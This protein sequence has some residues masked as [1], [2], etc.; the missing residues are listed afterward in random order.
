MTERMLNMLDVKGQ[1]MIVQILRMSRCA[2]SI[3]DAIY[4]YFG[5]VCF[6]SY[7]LLAHVRT[8]LKT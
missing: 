6:L 8:T 7:D 2:I 4:F 3:S 1:N 5:R